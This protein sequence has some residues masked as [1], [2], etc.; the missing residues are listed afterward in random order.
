MA[1]TSM[2][3]RT[4]CAIRALEACGKHVVGARVNGR[5]I[6]VETREGES[7]RIA[8]PKKT[9]DDDG[10]GSEGIIL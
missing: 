2:E 8:A 6:W 3:E 7:I 5:G 4:E 1:R 10:D 9:D